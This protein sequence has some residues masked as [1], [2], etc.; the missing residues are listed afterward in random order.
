MGN[1]PL[2]SAA[3]SA[4]RDSLALL[5]SRESRVAVILML[6]LAAA[7][8]SSSALDDGH[9]AGPAA[10]GAPANDAQGD[11]TATCAPPPP[12]YVICPAEDAGPKIEHS[13]AVA[14]AADRDCPAGQQC[15]FP[16]EDGC[17]A[18]G[19][20]LVGN[21]NDGSCRLPS[22][23]CGCDGQPV[24]AVVATH[25]PSSLKIEYT[26]GPFGKIGPCFA[27]DGGRSIDAPSP[28]V[29]AAD[30]HDDVAPKLDAGPA[31]IPGPCDGIVG[32]A[33]LVA[34]VEAT[35]VS[36]G[37]HGGY[38]SCE[39]DARYSAHVERTLCGSVG[40][41]INVI[42]NALGPDITQPLL[43][44][45]H[46]ILLL[47]GYACPAYRPEDMVMDVVGRY[48]L[49]DWDRLAAM[50]HHPDAGP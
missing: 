24:A 21:C 9:D 33:G 20:C 30:A 27:G 4:D 2:G 46:A 39:G 36:Q 3:S 19:V 41:A 50:L 31:A 42:A 34:V 29:D 38:A 10:D 26:S 22:G 18:T 12:N 28:L 16:L 13:P 23:L 37:F 6:A 47:T 45:E 25:E 11:G 49:S 48:P 14:C 5:P 35:G 17:R 43:R 7:G 8:C 15:G 40:P 32:G 1:A 44:D